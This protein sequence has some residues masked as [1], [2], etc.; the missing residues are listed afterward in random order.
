MSKSFSLQAEAREEA[1]KGVSRSLRRQGKLP[2]VIYGDN[3]TPVKIA[4]SAHNV[5][6]EYHK[7]HMFTSLCELD[8]DGK[9]HIVLARDVQLH[10]VTDFVEH[11][12]FLRVTDKTELKVH[13]SLQFIN[14]EQSPGLKDKGSL[15]VVAHQVEVVCKAENI[16][17][18]I[19]VDLSGKNHGE[20]VN[21]SSAIMPKGARPASDRDFTVANIV[22]PKR[23]KP[24]K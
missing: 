9:K 8:L 6:L 13:V 15:N 5:N 22:A 20:T 7:A 16:P 10:P 4:L 24:T 19:E 23:A 14:H 2:A 1:G 21:I 12:D 18:F 17:D 11:V 3:K